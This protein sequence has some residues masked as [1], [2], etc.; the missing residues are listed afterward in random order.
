V[1][2]CWTPL[3]AVPRGSKAIIVSDQLL[4]QYEDWT[5]IP[6]NVQARVVPTDDP[7][8]VDLQSRIV[9]PEGGQK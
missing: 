7:H 4:A 3:V 5:A 1:A 8:V 9:E 2:T 6:E